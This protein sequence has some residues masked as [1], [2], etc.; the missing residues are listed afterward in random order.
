MK[1]PLH[2]RILIGFIVGTAAGVLANQVGGAWVDTV[3]TYL[4]QPVG[5]IFLR[6]L[7]M[8]VIPLLFS[9]LVLGVAELGDVRTLG[10]I[11]W[12]TLA[13]TVVV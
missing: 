7:F 1:M 11:G 3:V 9:A 10:R 5:Q 2:T 13:Y 6:L 12:R 8:L 4:T